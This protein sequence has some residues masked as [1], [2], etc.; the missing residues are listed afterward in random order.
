M[1][2][3]PNYAFID[4]QNLNIGVSRD[5]FY[6]ERKIYSGWKLDFEKLFIYLKDKFKIE[7]A[8]LFIG[9]LSGQEK[10][11]S[12]LESYGYTLILKPTTNYLDEDGRLRVKG[13]VDTDLVLYAAAKEY[14]NYSKAII[15][16]GDGDFLSLCEFL[17]N[18][19]KL[20]YLNM[21]YCRA[22]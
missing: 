14:K 16:S 17:D 9:K 22:N 6:E 5:V 3:K 1:K 13:N 4:S 7:K 8:F 11:Y 10:L 21:D 19:K 12:N 20:K 15:V 2:N 18:N